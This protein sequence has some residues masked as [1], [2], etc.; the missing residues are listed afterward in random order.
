MTDYQYIEK[1]FS[2]LHRASL[3]GVMFTMTSPTNISLVSDLFDANIGLYSNDVNITNLYWLENK[4]SFE[5][6][7]RAKALQ[8]KLEQ[9]ALVN[10]AIGKLTEDE[11]YAL[12]KHFNVE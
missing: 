5:E 11:L 6:R 1:L 4:V 7:I 10:D 8:R 2:V 12:K 3:L 9:R